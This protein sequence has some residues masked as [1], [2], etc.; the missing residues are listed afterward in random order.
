[1]KIPQIQSLR[2]LFMLLIVASHLSMIGFPPFDA[3]GDCGVAFF[4]VLSGYITMM[5]RHSQLQDGTFSHK[6]YLL[7]N[8]RR[9]YPLYIITWVIAVLLMHN[10]D[11]LLH[12][13]PSLI[14]VQSWIPD[15][16][17]YFGGNSVGWFLSTLLLAWLTLPWVY[18]LV[19]ARYGILALL[20]GYLLIAFIVPADKVNVWL[21]V[22][23]PVRLVDFALGMALYLWCKPMQLCQTALSKPQ[24]LYSK[25]ISNPQHTTLLSYL[26]ILGI[27]TSL[28]AYP[29]LPP[30]LRNALIF[31]P[32][33]CLI[34]ATHHSLPPFFNR[35]LSH[36]S[37]VSLGN[38]TFEIFLTHQLILRIIAKCMHYFS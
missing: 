4:F 18:K 23:P 35:L 31:W 1:M 20:A 21:Y 6:K 15:P 7:K 17:F 13:L 14:L 3:G 22:F 29:Y 8:L 10:L 16:Q 9:T 2:F 38:H 5:S 19:K 26:G 36:P 32:F 12:A 11:H 24:L 37:L 34:I 33:I 28:C 30:Q 25:L 27:I